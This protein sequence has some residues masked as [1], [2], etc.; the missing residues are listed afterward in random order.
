MTTNN[1]QNQP[2]Q[3]AENERQIALQ[4]LLEME[5]QGAFSNLAL[6]QRLPKSGK[7]NGF[8]TALVY[9]VAER[10]LTLDAI[11]NHYAGKK[12]LDAEI[13]VLLRM[14]IYQLLYLE[15]V[16][17]NTAVNE[18]VKLCY[19]VRKVSAKGFVNA[20]LRGFL[21]DGK[22]LPPTANETE[23]LSLHYSCPM[24]LIQQWQREYGTEK[25]CGLLEASVQTPPLYV[26]VNTMK[27]T[28]E[29]V[30]KELEAAGITV[31]NTVLSDAWQLEHS[32]NLERLPAFRDGH[33]Y[34]QDLAS[35]I[36]AAL[37]EVCPGETVYDLCAAPGSKSFTMAQQ[38]QNTGTILAFDLYEHKQ[39]L[40][41][42]GAKK[43]GLET[44]EAKIGDACVFEEALPQADCVLCDVPCAG[45]GIIRRKPEIKYK[46]PQTLAELPH[47]QYQI[48]QNGARYVKP[49]GRLIYSTCS[50]SH[51]ENEQVA[52]RFLQEHPAFEALPIPEAY[53]A[54]AE[55]DSHGF[56]TFFPNRIGSDGFFIARFRRKNEE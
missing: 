33:F 38:M 12:K 36:C 21:R 1:K 23:R 7:G 56:M 25:T 3:Q 20:I 31:Q 15:R 13:R 52:E 24:W 5:L 54:W 35:Q 30:K 47:L 17:D 50:L 28:A 4:I 43:L 26:R 32:G 27:T 29:A 11:I 49:G 19:T 14:G 34:V 48:L 55:A 22:K 37:T 53:A 2:P 42:Q 18:T 51:A 44:I 8:I 45:L 41:E 40:I 16:A 46:E 39:T 10:R 9:G 6:Q